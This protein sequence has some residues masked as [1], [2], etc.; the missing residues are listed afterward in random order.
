MNPAP[1]QQM[2]MTGPDL[3]LV[4]LAA[5]LGVEGVRIDKVEDIAPVLARAVA[6]NR[7]FLAEIAIEGKG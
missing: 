4:H 3:D 1:H 2:G 5:G 7:P 6:A